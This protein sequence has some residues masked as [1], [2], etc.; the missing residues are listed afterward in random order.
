MLMF[1][2]NYYKCY[3][4][5]MEREQQIIIFLGIENMILRLS[6]VQVKDWGFLV[7]GEMVLLEFFVE[8]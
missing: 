8:K 1:F 6:V 2:E 5:I 3:S 4:Y 7:Q